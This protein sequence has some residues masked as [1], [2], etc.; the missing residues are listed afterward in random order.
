MNKPKFSLAFATPKHMDRICEIEQQS[1]ADPWSRR[2]IAKAMDRSD[3][4]PMIAWHHFR[5]VGFMFLANV[6]NRIYIIDLAV[7]PKWRR[8]GVGTVMLNHVKN[9]LTKQRGGV[10]TAEV[11][12]RNLEG[13]LFMRASGFTCVDR[14]QGKLDNSDEAYVFEHKHRYPSTLNRIGGLSFVNDEL[15]KASS[16]DASEFF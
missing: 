9:R 7:E 8:H 12:E 2:E 1:F 6:R 11:W 13:Q 10:A 5:L 15:S 4:T 14:V 3:V 16:D